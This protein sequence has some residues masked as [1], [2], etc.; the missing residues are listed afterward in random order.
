MQVYWARKKA[1]ESLREQESDLSIEDRLWDAIQIFAR[2]RFV[3]A[4][5]LA[6]YYIVSGN[7][8]MVDWKKKSIVRSSVNMALK[9]YWIHM[10]RSEAPKSWASMAQ[11]I[12]IPCFRDLA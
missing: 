4:K 5:G 9:K 8:I 11:A 10:A 7:E 2:Y 6:F 12:S 3:A 1:V